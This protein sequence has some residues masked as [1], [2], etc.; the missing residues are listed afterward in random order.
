M[1]GNVN[2]N[3]AHLLL[4]TPNSIFQFFSLP[5]WYGFLN[6][7]V[8]TT[9]FT[10]YKCCPTCVTACWEAIES[11]PC[12]SPAVFW[13]LYSWCGAPR[14]SLL[15]WWARRATGWVLPEPP[16]P[17][18]KV[19]G[20]GH[21]TSWALCMMFTTIIGWNTCEAGPHLVSTQ[22]KMIHLW[23]VVSAKVLVGGGVW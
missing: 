10:A 13:S 12:P 1:E 5:W 18:C 9:V 14:W 19:V 3:G 11:L 7:C 21:I 4:S 23:A 20:G 22:R 15:C 8:R 6:T 17:S 2:I 16:P